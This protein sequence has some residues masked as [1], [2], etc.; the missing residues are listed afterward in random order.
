MTVHADG[1]KLVVRGPRRAEAMAKR[2]LAHKA[3]IMPVLVSAGDG[4]PIDPGWPPE[5][6]QHIKWFLSSQPPSEPFEL[7]SGVTILKPEMFWE[8]VHQDIRNGPGCHRDIWGAVRNDLRRLYE[9]FGP[10]EEVA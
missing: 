7:V 9:R 8:S 2:L 3:E 10:R 4:P 1:D 5:T 6:R